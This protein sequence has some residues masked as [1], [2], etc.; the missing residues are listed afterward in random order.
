[1]TKS[2]FLHLRVLARRLAR[3][4]GGLAA[5]EFAIILP[6]MLLMYL[7]SYEIT[8]A[9]AI[10]RLVAL[11]ASTVAN[12]TT[13]YATI[14]QSSTLPDILNAATTVLT[15]YPATNAVVTI[16]VIQIDSSGKGT[17]FWSQ[18]STGAGHT[19]G[20]S[21]TVPAAIA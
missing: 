5:V 17:I 3:H 11:T 18:A 15:P 8:T 6:F 9:I 10:K 21:V 20:S 16:S 7:G 14:S 2:R 13:Q 12:V 4:R 19:Q 1:M